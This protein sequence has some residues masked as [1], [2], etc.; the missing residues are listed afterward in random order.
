MSRPS[1]KELHKLQ[2]ETNGE[3]TRVTGKG[4]TNPV[5]KQKIFPDEVS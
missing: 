2:I 3:C 5:K 1:R 4:K